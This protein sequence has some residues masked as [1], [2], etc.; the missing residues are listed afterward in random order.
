VLG[1]DNAGAVYGYVMRKVLLYAAVAVVVAAGVH[2]PVTMVSSVNS[3]TAKVGQPFVFRT[4]QMVRAGDVTIPAGTTGHGV[5][6][7]VSPAA[8]THRGELTLE[9][10]E[11]DLTNSEHVPVQPLG[12]SSY[13][14]R[15]HVFPFPVPVPGVVVVGGAVNPGG[16]VT[17]GPGT[18]FEVITGPS[19]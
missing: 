4:T 5:V 7:A 6:S 12:S 19:R 9:P 13:V 18:S 10:Q 11:L 14:A 1:D 15:R 2:I 16:N 17:I 8:G 3:G